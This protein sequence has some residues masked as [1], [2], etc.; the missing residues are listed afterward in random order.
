MKRSNCYCQK[1][2]LLHKS[3]IIQSW[4]VKK[5][6]IKNNM[7]IMNPPCCSPPRIP[8]SQ[9]MAQSRCLVVTTTL[10]HQLP[11]YPSR[12]SHVNTNSPN[13]NINSSNMNT[14]SLNM[15]VSRELT[16]RELSWQVSWLQLVP[17]GFKAH[18]G[19]YQWQVIR[20]WYYLWVHS[21]QGHVL[22]K[23][24]IYLITTAKLPSM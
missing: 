16:P 7:T 13:M 11:R 14:V 12:I 20:I 21:S 1:L 5:N 2:S 23:W 6:S 15:Y 9:L 3:D 24:L 10:L 4:T 17:Q 19:V 22:L 18:Q 8:A